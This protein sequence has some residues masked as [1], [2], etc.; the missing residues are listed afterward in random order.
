MWLLK[1]CDNCDNRLVHLDFESPP[2]IKILLRRSSLNNFLLMELAHLLHQTRFFRRQSCWL[3]DV[4]YQCI[5][6]GHLSLVIVNEDVQWT[7]FLVSVCRACIKLLMLW[8]GLALEQQS[9]TMFTS[10]M[11]M[12]R[13]NDYTKAISCSIQMWIMWK[14]E[15]QYHIDNV[16][17]EKRIA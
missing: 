11:R 15:E 3:F 5:L 2:E 1:M 17:K 13:L 9:R 6:S 7:L 12:K 4:S 14:R 16:F 8:A 10:W